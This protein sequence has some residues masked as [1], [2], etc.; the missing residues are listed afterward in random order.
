MKSF[1]LLDQ[2]FLPVIR[3]NEYAEISLYDMLHEAHTIERIDGGNPVVTASLYRLCLA[4]SMSVHRK[5]WAGKTKQNCIKEILKLRQA[6]KFEDELIVSYLTIWQDRFNIS[7]AKYPFFQVPMKDMKRFD[8][9]ISWE[10]SK[11]ISKLRY[12]DDNCPTL[13]DHSM[14]SHEESMT[15]IEV[16]KWLITY[17]TFV[18]TCGKLP[19]LHSKSSPIVKK[20]GGLIYLV[21]GDNLFDT[22]CLNMSLFGERPEEDELEDKPVWEKPQ[23]FIPKKEGTVPLGPL[24]I[25]TWQSRWILLKP[26]ED[27][28]FKQCLI[29][30]GYIFHDSSLEPMSMYDVDDKGEQRPRKLDLL[31]NNWKDYQAIVSNIEVKNKQLKIRKP[32]AISSLNHVRIKDDE[33]FTIDVFGMATDKSEVKGWR[34]QSW[35]LRPNFLEDEH[36]YECVCYITTTTNEIWSGL[37]CA[38]GQIA[39]VLAGSQ[40][41][42]KIAKTAN[43]FREKISVFYWPVMSKEF[44]DL[45]YAMVNSVSY[46]GSEINGGHDEIL[47]N[48]QTSWKKMCVNV[49]RKVLED[50][51]K[52]MAPSPKKIIAFYGDNNKIYGAW[53]KLEIILAKYKVN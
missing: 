53:S 31:K 12:V 51:S 32:L 39:S 41:K 47:A 44:Q 4:L 40:N 16:A 26:E 22:L 8:K 18:P 7:D 10:D 23:F 1:D 13:F 29:R 43:Y 27:F 3:N 33:I 52:E 9:N 19:V 20:G 17:Q 35:P 2:P 38:V 45:T 37:R 36:V 28:S 34:Q 6:R 15:A 5:L 48:Y 46:N 21:M 30:Q 50:I 11:P 42:D 49:A 24:D 14:D 25:L